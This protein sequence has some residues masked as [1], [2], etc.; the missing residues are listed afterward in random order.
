MK[1]LRKTDPMLKHVAPC[2]QGAVRSADL[3]TFR[4]AHLRP[5]AESFQVICM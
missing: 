2:Q 3:L 4:G 5:C 1:A